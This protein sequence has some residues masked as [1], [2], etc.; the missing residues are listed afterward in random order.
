MIKIKFKYRFEQLKEI[1]YPSTDL[2]FYKLYNP[3]TVFFYK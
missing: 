1:F 2:G 3:E